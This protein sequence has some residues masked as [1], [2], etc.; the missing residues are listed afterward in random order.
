MAVPAHQKSRRVVP[1]AVMTIGIQAE[2]LVDLV[3]APKAEVIIQFS[4]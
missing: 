2:D 1:T 3:L 4:V